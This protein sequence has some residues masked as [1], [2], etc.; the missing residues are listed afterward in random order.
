MENN[1]E[2]LSKA[3]WGQYKKNISSYLALSF[4][5]LLVGA[6]ILAVEITLSFYGMSGTLIFTIPFIFIP[7]VFAVQYSM[8]H[9]RSGE[10]ISSKL[11]GGG[12]VRYMNIASPYF[13][14]YRVIVSFLK[15]L[16]S[17]MAPYFVTAMIYIAVK[18]ATDSSFVEAI[19]KVYEMLKDES[20]SVTKIY[21]YIA[22]SREILGIYV[23]ASGV[24]YGV[25]SYIF[26]RSVFINSASTYIRGMMLGGRAHPRVANAI[27]Q[28]G[29]RSIR[30]EYFKEYYKAMW[31]LIPLLIIGFVGGYIIPCVLPVEIDI[32]AL[33][34]FGF[35]GQLV[36]VAFFV[37]YAFE[38]QQILTFTYANN[39]SKASLDLAKMNLNQLK[40]AQQMSEEQSKEIEDQIKQAEAKMKEAEEKGENPF[41]AVDNENE[42]DSSEE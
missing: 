27:F 4:V 39:Y 37:P 14:S 23:C 15:A 6:V 1:K 25:A 13:G 40:A 18:S 5:L 42:G 33:P 24:G 26:I 41:D 21:E 38:V 22:S 9:V 29:F 34:A 2:S 17:Y 28:Y 31:P 10:N 16:L 19:N 7:F 35:A 36:L 8:T 12:W 11:I 3:A 32:T 30:R 20:I